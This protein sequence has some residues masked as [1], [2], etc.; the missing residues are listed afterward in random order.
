MRK[1]F[2]RED[3][4]KR[5]VVEAALKEANG[6]LSVFRTEERRRVSINNYSCIDSLLLIF[7]I[8]VDEFV[9]IL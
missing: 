6:I 7:V 1:T 3:I 4:E 9:Y 8:C 5:Y 2:P